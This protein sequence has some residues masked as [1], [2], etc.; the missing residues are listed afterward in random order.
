M[1]VIVCGDRNWTDRGLLFS[2]LDTQHEIHGFTQLVSGGCRGVDMLADQWAR[3][4]GIESRVFRADWERHGK[5]AGPL[6][7][8][9][10]LDD[11]KPDAVIGVHYNLRNSRGTLHMLWIAWNA[12]VGIVVYRGPGV[13]STYWRRPGT[14]ISLNPF[15][16]MMNDRR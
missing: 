16:M 7:N 8:H 5:R 13:P 12:G 6:R 11:G 9:E 15:A 3:D 14:E 10:M 1:K 2:K 4:R